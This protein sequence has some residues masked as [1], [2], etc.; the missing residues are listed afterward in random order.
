MDILNVMITDKG[1][2]Y[3]GAGLAMIGVLGIGIGQGVAG[4]KAVEGIARNPEVLSKLRTQFILSA[5][6]T[7]TGA[8]YA[9]IVAILLIFVA[10]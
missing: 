9:L 10:S 1:M 6:L 4:A 2:A 7:E 3:L 8:I 5:A